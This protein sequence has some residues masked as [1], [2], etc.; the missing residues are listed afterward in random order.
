MAETTTSNGRAK[1][2]SKTNA[3]GLVIERQEI[4]IPRK[5]C[6]KVRT[7][8]SHRGGRQEYWI[9][10]KTAAIQL[11]IELSPTNVRDGS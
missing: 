1:F 4:A 9:K 8:T 3:C 10:A 5:K 6:V 2:F 11:W 7:P